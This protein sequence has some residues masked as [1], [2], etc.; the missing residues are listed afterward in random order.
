MG[1]RKAIKKFINLKKTKL[2]N[3]STSSRK[4]NNIDKKEIELI[5]ERQILGRI[6]RENFLEIKYLIKVSTSKEEQKDNLGST[7]DL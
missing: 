2:C 5:P 3:R 4:K 6:L 1:I 7:K